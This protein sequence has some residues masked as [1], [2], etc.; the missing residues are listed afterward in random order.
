MR[1]GRTEL[2]TGEYLWDRKDR[3]ERVQDDIYDV[4]HGQRP[5]KA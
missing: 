4:R 1:R 3:G 2:L 5:K